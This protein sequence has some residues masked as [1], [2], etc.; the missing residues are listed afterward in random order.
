MYQLV[1]SLF[2]FKDLIYKMIT[3]ATQ[4]VLFGGNSQ[5]SQG[6]SYI[7]GYGYQPVRR[8]APRG[9]CRSDKDDSGGP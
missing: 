5:G 1:A 2:P 7:P 9:D 3:G 4:M 6:G 8:D